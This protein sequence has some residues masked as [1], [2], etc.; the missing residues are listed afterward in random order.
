MSTLDQVL[1]SVINDTS[2][3][4]PLS[5]QNPENNLTSTLDDVLK[6]ETKQKPKAPEPILAPKEEPEEGPAQAVG[7]VFEETTRVVGSSAINLWNNTL[8]S[9]QSFSD[10]ANENIYDFSGLETRKDL[11]PKIDKPDILKPQTRFGEI[12]DDILPFFFGAG[13]F[14]AVGAATKIGSAAATGFAGGTVVDFLAQNPDDGNLADLA[15]HVFPELKGDIMEWLKSDSDA[16]EFERR[17]HNSI[18]NG[19]PFGVGVGVW[20]LF[21]LGKETFKARRAGKGDE[22]I[23]KELAGDYKELAD[24]VDVIAKGNDDYK[25]WVDSADED[26]ASIQGPAGPEDMFETNVITKAEKAVHAASDPYEPIP[27]MPP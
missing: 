26:L 24:E 16:P 17:L 13:V 12:A 21:K 4:Q 9:I 14:G 18:V 25:A 11:I 23:A 6:A 19:I 22:T 3:N 15:E 8:S 5:L 20:K 1:N 10:W 2:S 27:V 7:D